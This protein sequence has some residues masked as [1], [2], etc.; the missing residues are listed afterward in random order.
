MHNHTVFLLSLLLSTTHKRGAEIG[1]FEGDT[2]VALLKHL[3]E[4][5][6]LVCVDPFLRYPA[7]D[8]STPKKFGKVARADLD[9]TMKYFLERTKVFGN[10]LRFIHDMSESGALHV[11][12]ESL[13]FV[14]I[15][16]NHAYGYV[17]TDIECWSPKVKPGGLIIG[18]DFVNKPGY[19]VIE[20]VREAFGD[21]FYHDR[22]STCWWTVKK[23]G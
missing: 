22:K 20:A 3:T 19:G 12:D 11:T 15:D 21:N 8:A 10:R 1:V 7:F 16:G 2:S 13:D 5:E 9:E 17:K 4:L 14:F 6:E 23:E 18:H